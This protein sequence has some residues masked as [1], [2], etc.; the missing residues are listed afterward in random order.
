MELKK[1]GQTLVNK[2]FSGSGWALVTVLVWELLEEALESLIA[3][4]I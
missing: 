2:L 1:N 4:C 3:L